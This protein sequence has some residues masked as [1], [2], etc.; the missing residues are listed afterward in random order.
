MRREGFASRPTFAEFLDRF[1]ILAFNASHKVRVDVLE[2]PCKLRRCSHPNLRPQ[3]APTPENCVA[4]LH[5]VGLRE[6]RV[7]NTRVFLKYWHMDELTQR[8]VQQSRFAITFQVGVYSET[9]FLC[10]QLIHSSGS[11]PCGCSQMY[12]SA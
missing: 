3:L 12:H 8:L 2:A 7:G 1:M 10:L 11:V 9:R 4:V 6:W 5:R